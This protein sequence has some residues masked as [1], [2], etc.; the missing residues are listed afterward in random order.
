[1]SAIVLLT[2]F[3]CVTAV[4]IVAAAAFMEVAFSRPDSLQFA[5]SVGSSRSFDRQV[6]QVSGRAGCSNASA[7]CRSCIPLVTE[8]EAAAIA[9]EIRSRFDG[10]SNRVLTRAMSRG[11]GCPMLTADGLCACESARPLVCLGR[12]VLGADSPESAAGLSR[13]ISEA[14]CVEMQSHHRDIHARPLDEALL[15][16]VG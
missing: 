2:L 6:Q 7:V 12:G 11:G 10:E 15:E 3:C 4:A 1:M 9:A 5:G 14:V 8:P 16:L 13:A